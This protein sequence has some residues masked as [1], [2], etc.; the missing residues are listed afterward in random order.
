ML[1]PDQPKS[2][3]SAHAVNGRAISRTMMVA[4]QTALGDSG[5]PHI[6]FGRVHS[7]QRLYVRVQREARSKALKT[8]HRGT[9]MPQLAIMQTRTGVNGIQGCGR[10]ERQDTEVR[11]DE[12]PSGCYPPVLAKDGGYL[13]LEYDRSQ[14]ERQT[15]MICFITD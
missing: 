4:T 5:S 15:V 3:P 11:R 7:K 13:S 2:S 6:P 10:V 8:P 14:I 12:R 9:L 1:V